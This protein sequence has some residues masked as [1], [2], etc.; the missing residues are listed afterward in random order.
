MMIKLAVYFLSLATASE[1]GDYC[2]KCL[3]CVFEEYLCWRKGWL[4]TF[5]AWQ[6]RVRRKYRIK[7]LNKSVFVEYLWWQRQR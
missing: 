5:L 1:A 2:V 7:C 4:S 3:D 6:Q